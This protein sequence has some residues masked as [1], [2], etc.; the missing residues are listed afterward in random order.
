VQQSVGTMLLPVVT[1]CALVLVVLVL[2]LQVVTQCLICAR[3]VKVVISILLAVLACFVSL[4]L[5]LFLVLPMDYPITLLV[6]KEVRTFL[7]VLEPM[8]VAALKLLFPKKSELIEVD[9]N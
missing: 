1:T 5:K 2:K 9:Y 6:P 4:I 3:Q 8:L 7:P